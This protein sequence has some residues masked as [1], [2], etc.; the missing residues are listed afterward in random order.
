MILL[1]T[2]FGLDGPYIGQVKAALIRDAPGIPVV[3]LLADAPAFRPRESAYLLAALAERFPAGATFLCV[4]DPGVGGTRS[5][6]A[7]RIDGRWFVGPGNGLFEPLLRR[8]REVAG[9]AIPVPAAPISASFHGRDLFAPAAA[10]LARGEAPERAGLVPAAPARHPDWP[11]HLAA[12]IYVDRFG[13]LMT[14]LRAGLVPAGSDLELAGLRLRRARTFSDVPPDGA[15][16]YENSIGLAEIAVRE[17]SAAEMFGAG[18]GT[19]VGMIVAA[20]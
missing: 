5:A 14:G 6:E 13:N 9:F 16:W 3:D 10:R 4:V 19:E 12:V 2:D 18:A 7:V 20:M 17:G 11:D 1:F 8:A 15:F